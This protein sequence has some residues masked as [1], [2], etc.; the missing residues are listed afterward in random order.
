M[1]DKALINNL[2]GKVYQFEDGD[3]IQVIQIKS[4]NEDDILITVHITQGPGI[5]RKLV[6]SIGEFV[7]SYGHLFGLVEDFEKP[8]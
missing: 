3:K 2:V 5:P 1:I 7:E 6:F 4:R 8:E